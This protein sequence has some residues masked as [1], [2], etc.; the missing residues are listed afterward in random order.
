MKE[1]KQKENFST[2]PNYF[3]Q[4]EESILNET[5]R[6]SDA[7]SFDVP[8][9]YFIALEEKILQVNN[10]SKNL[11]KVRK[12]W[13]A[14]SSVAACMLLFTF[15]Y[16]QVKEPDNNSN[17]IV[18]YNVGDNDIDPDVER[19]VYESLYRSYFADDD[20][21]KSS[22]EI[23]LDDLDDFYSDQQLSSSY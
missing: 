3:D 2:P 12:L 15:V 23:T 6:F 19:A 17:Y 5:K 10:K 14:V 9:V 16:F 21:K 13:F 11:G 8:P 18:D 1:F 4:L 22:N 7:S 20:T